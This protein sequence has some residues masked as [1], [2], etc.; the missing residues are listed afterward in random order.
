MKSPAIDRRQSAAYGLYCAAVLAL[1]AATGGCHSFPITLP[2]Q[3]TDPPDKN[4][5]A[6]TQVRASG[7]GFVLGDVE[8]SAISPQQ[9]VD[10]LTEL[11]HAGRAGAAVRWVEL[12]PDVA[13][14]VLHEPAQ[15]AAAPELL[16]VIASAHDRQCG[17]APA[18]AGWTAL[19]RDRAANPKRY[20]SYDQK[21]REFMTLVQSGQAAEALKLGL[22]PPAARRA[23]CW[24]S[25]RFT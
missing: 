23:R 1:L 13:A 21:R 25:T 19:C 22:A 11:H 7:D 8:K 4:P 5:A 3:T 6:G 2:W 17:R 12:Y 10:R 16:A 9:F 24:R 18:A 14:A 15:A 20:A